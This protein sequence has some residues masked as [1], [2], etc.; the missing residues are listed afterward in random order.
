MLIIRLNDQITQKEKKAY[1]SATWLFSNFLVCGQSAAFDSNSNLFAATQNIH[2]QR[3][4]NRKEH[5]RTHECYKLF[6][7]LPEMVTQAAKKLNVG[8]HFQRY[9]CRFL[10]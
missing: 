7:K 5:F 9:E 10:C 2:G 1:V 6:E 8:R 3:R 4:N